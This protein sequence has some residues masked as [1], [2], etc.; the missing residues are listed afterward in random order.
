MRFCSFL[1]PAPV[2]EGIEGPD[3]SRTVPRGEGPSGS[4]LF[5]F[6]SSPIFRIRPVF[7]FIRSTN[8]VRTPFTPP[9][10]NLPFVCVVEAFAD[11]RKENVIARYEFPNFPRKILRLEDNAPLKKS[12]IKKKSKY[13]TTL[14]ATHESHDPTTACNCW[15]YTSR[16]NRE[17]TAENRPTIARG[18]GTLGTRAVSNGPGP[19]VNV[20]VFRWYRSSV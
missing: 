20:F 18:L 10:S 16:D 5:H 14:T 17:A 2:Q 12:D 4:Q 3:E 8:L 7:P 9:L 1:G 15:W 19:P 13:L 6:F 11:A